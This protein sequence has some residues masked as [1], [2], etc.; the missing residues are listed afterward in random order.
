[1]PHPGC[2]K[3]VLLFKPAREFIG[4]SGVK[5]R[6]VIIDRIIFGK[7]DQGYTDETIKK[8]IFQHILK[9]LLILS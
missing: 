4:I 3:S 2:R 9:Q 8:L 5:Y 1:M 7:C 6:S